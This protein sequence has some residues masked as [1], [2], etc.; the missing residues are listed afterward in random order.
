MNAGRDPVE[1]LRR[2]PFAPPLRKARSAYRTIVRR[3][4]ILHA[5]DATARSVNRLSGRERPRLSVVIATVGRDSLQRA[6]DSAGWADQVIVVYDAAVVPSGAPA[7]VDY[8]VGPTRHWGAEQRNLGIS[9]AA[10]THVAFLDDDDVY[11]EGAGEAVLRAVAAW[12]RRVHIFRM[13]R[14]DN[15]F[16]GQDCIWLGGVGTPMF[17]VPNDHRIASWTTRRAGDFDFIR[18]TLDASRRAPRFHD[19]VIALV[20]PQSAIRGRENA[21]SERAG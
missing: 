8:A 14:G 21:S 7:G 15:V 12:R 16:G 19:D 18:S 5:A 1:W 13:R 2:S 20:D 6:V 3:S 9:K 11:T 10:G 4:G 17:V